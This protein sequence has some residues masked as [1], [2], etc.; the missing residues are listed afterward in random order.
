MTECVVLNVID[1]KLSSRL[2]PSANAAHAWCWCWCCCATCFS[3]HGQTLCHD[4][5][6]S[7]L[8]LQ[9]SGA[10]AALQCAGGAH[11]RS[12]GSGRKGNIPRFMA[13]DNLEFG[14]VAALHIGTLLGASFHALG[15]ERL[16]SHHIWITS[17]GKKWVSSMRG[18][19]Q[20]TGIHGMCNHCQSPCCAPRVLL[21][22]A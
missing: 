9:V 17:G 7:Q 20:Y 13:T 8:L 16:L 6:F 5:C 11:G 21:T 2:T 3:S 1:D 14:V 19:Y 22:V 4:H 10:G 18:V 15:D 12:I